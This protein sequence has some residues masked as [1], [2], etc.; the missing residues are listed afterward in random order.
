M[1]IFES[2]SEYQ[3]W[4]KNL[5]VDLTLGF[6]PTMGA[7]HEGHA[8]LLENS[9]QDRDLT[10]LSIF[11]NP[12]QFNQLEDFEKYPKTLE[13][14]L[15]LAESRGVDAVFLPQKDEIYLDGYNY[16][17]VELRDS[18][19]LCGRFRPG[20][21]EGMLTIVLKLFQIVQPHQAFFGEKD[22][23][24]FHLIKEMV[25]AFFLPIAI[26]PVATVREPS[27]LALSSRNAR[28]S[29]EGRMRASLLFKLL[30]QVSQ[31]EEI[32]TKLIQAGFQ[33]EYVED[34]FDRRFVAA[35]LEGIRLI[36]N[37][38]LNRI[39]GFDFSKGDSV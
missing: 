30:S 33:V 37:V 18:K 20:H 1:K 8:Q 36:D 17:I 34:H 10:V 19:I 23:Q 4:R 12:T 39:P 22:Y 31:I 16:Q 11:V 7:L 13:A 24:Q 5:P 2:I 35:W 26:T 6:V 32:E 25:N 9:R 29:A 14:D 15:K 38:Y 21:F 27:G 28:L 3:L